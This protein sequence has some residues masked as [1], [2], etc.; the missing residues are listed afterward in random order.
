MR[1]SDLSGV[2]EYWVV[3]FSVLIFYQL[4]DFSHDRETTWGFLPFLLPILHVPL[5]LS[6]QWLSISFS[7]KNPTIYGSYLAITWVNP[8]IY[9]YG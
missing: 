3:V 8:V 5:Y 2:F 9:C 4:V 6:A 1:V 7:K